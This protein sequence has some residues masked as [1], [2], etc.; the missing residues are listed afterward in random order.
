M[1]FS[2][3]FLPDRLRDAAAEKA[4]IQ[5]MLDAEAAVARAEA[6]AGVIPFQATFSRYFVLTAM[7]GPRRL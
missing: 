6:H 2:P 5:A 3:L 1:L 7:R 4:W